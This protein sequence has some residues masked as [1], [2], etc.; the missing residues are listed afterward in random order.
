MYLVVHTRVVRP[1]RN[2]RRPYRIVEVR[3]EKGE[4]WTLALEPVNHAGLKFRS[5]QYAW[6]TIGNTPFKLQQHP[7]S[8]SSSARQSQ[9]TFSAKALGDFTSSWKDIEPGTQAYLEGPFGAFTLESYTKGAFFIVG[10]IGI[11]PAMSILR[12]MR[13]QRDPRPVTL[14]YGNANENEI[15]FQEELETLTQVLDLQVVHVLEEPPEAWTGHT[16]YVDKELLERYLPKNKNEYEY[17][18]CGPKPMMDSAESALREMGIPW[19]RIFSERFQI[20]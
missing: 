1:W 3:D 20:V 7:F 6:I 8:I 4:V 17:F 11:T 16:G 9:I 15:T 14:L 12:T 18:I 19:L 10:G 5:G 13:D 2:R